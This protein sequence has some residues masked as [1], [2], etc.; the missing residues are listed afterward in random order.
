M[1][2]LTENT[3]QF[4]SRGATRCLAERSVPRRLS[5]R[6]NRE[7]K[8]LLL[9]PVGNHAIIDLSHGKGVLPHMEEIAVVA[10]DELVSKTSAVSDF[11]S[12]LGLNGLSTVLSALIVFIIC[13]IVIK[14]FCRL[15]DQIFAR[16]RHID[17]T[18]KRFLRTAVKIVLWTLAIVIV[19]GALGIPT[20]S[21]VAVI[22]VAG[23]ALSL[24]VQNILSNLFSGITLLI[25]RPM[26]VGD[27]VEIGANAGNVHSIGLLYTVLVSPN[28]QVIT[29]PNGDV[30]SASIVNYNREP[31]RRAQ[32]TFNA[33][34]SDATEDVIAALLDAAETM[35]AVVHEPAPE[36]FINSYQD[37]TIEYGLNVWCDP[38]TYWDVVHG[39]NG[40][41]RE[42]FTAHGVHMSY[43]HVNVH[44][45]Q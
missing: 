30:A 23:L 7:L 39:I 17:E 11:F 3:L 35:P 34:Y 33:D 44:L 41:V 4:T 40:L 31:L 25:S 21:L 8:N 28:K 26:S 27:Y 43:S 24:S 10:T 19:A 22:S 16:S 1:K 20:A 32:F 38:N 37:S 15:M 45:I 12:S 29:I 9:R 5:Q 18:V 42:Q 14:L 2:A 13:L 6:E 36:A